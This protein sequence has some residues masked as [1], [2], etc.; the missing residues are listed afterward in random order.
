VLPAAVA[1]LLVAIGWGVASLVVWLIVLITGRF[2]SPLF[3]ATVAVLRYS[4]RYTAYWWMLTRRYPR[5]LFGGEPGDEEYPIA[6]T[7]DL[8]AAPAVV[9]SPAERLDLSTAAKLIVVVLLILGLAG[10]V[11]DVKLNALA[12]GREDHNQAVSELNAAEQDLAASGSTYGDAVATCKTASEST[13]CLEHTAE[14][15]ADELD[16]FRAKVDNIDPP[17]GTES[18]FADLSTKTA[19]FADGFHQLADADGASEYT[20]VGRRLDL[21]TR[22]RA[23]DDANA[24]LI[25]KLNE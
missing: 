9:G 24:A 15:F 8:E 20:A 12:R 5:G 10:F 1:G 14:K 11:A 22:G 6:L 17:A 18:L 3:R 23:F 21:V 4:L 16:D 25:A 19:D 2:P 13:S 7:R